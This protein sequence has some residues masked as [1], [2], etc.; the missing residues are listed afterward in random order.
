MAYLNT[1]SA[2]MAAIAFWHLLF[3]DTGTVGNLSSTVALTFVSTFTAQW[4]IT[5]LCFAVGHVM[6]AKHARELFSLKHS[7][8]RAETVADDPACYLGACAICLDAPATH[9]FHP[10]NHLVACA[11]CCEAIMSTTRECPVCRESASSAGL[12]FFSA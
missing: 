4:L 6:F 3:G 8:Q 12:I 11:A 10:C 5:G 2:V 9:A 7:S 1:C